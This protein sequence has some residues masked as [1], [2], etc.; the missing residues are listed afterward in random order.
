MDI[1]YISSL[2]YD[3]WPCD[4]TTSGIGG[5]GTIELEYG[6]NLIAVPILYGYWDTTTSGLIHDESTIARIENYIID[7]LDGLYGT[8]TVEVSNSWVGDN[9]YF[10]SY[11]YG[12]TPS[13]SPH[14]FPLV[15]DD[16]GRNEILGVWIK[17]VGPAAPYIMYWG[18][19]P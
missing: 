17:I 10:Y 16:G 14:N 5:Y 4:T 13:S 11:V 18:E 2:G 3:F 9:Q 6:W 19:Q 7:Q 8:G 12:S 15:W 1:R